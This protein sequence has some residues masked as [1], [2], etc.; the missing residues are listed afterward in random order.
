M[1]NFLSV[2]EHVILVKVTFITF[3]DP[4]AMMGESYEEQHLTDLM[5]LQ[6]V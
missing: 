1:P 4:V 3:Y 6:N 5:M 2:I